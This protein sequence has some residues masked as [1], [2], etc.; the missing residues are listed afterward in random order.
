MRSLRGRW[1][2]SGSP[3][4]HVCAMVA[5]SALAPGYALPDSPASRPFFNHW[6]HPSGGGFCW[7]S[8]QLGFHARY[9][10]ARMPAEQAWGFSTG[11]ILTEK[12][13]RI[14]ISS[15]SEER[16]R[17]TECCPRIGRRHNKQ[18]KRFMC[19]M[20]LNFN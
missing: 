13:P 5:V 12:L 14:S 16:E 17:E 7:R 4:G 20:K 15:C 11:Y 2:C 9:P 3:P 8:T 1:L 18:Q 19:S 10:G 6:S